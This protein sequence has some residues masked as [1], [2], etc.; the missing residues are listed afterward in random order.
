V[1]ALSFTEGTRITT[2][3]PL[4]DP[5][6]GASLLWDGAMVSLE[7]RWPDD[8]DVARARYTWL[9]VMAQVERELYADDGTPRIDVAPER[10]GELLAAREAAMRTYAIALVLGWSISEPCTPESV[11]SLFRR[12]PFALS[13]VVNASGESDRFL[14]VS[15][16]T[17]A[18]ESAPSSAAPS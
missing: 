5:E 15:L 8:P 16:R 4:T 3:V 18:N 10:Q 2:T 12:A 6:S 7:I 13:L 14:P 11:A 9:A 1:I 17:A